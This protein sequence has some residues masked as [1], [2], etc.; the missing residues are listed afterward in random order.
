MM[1]IFLD[2]YMPGPIS[3]SC[4]SLFLKI[5][6]HVSRPEGCGSFS[7]RH[8]MLATSQVSGAVWG[9]EDLKG[10]SAEVHPVQKACKS[11]YSVLSPHGASGT[12]CAVENVKNRAEGAG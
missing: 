8:G 12:R 10:I 4:S 1:K 2:G 9:A 7:L 5:S 11:C 3:H 6:H